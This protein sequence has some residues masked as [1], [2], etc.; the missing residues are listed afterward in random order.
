MERR[1]YPVGIQTFSRLRREG[2]VY[3][4]KTDLVWQLVNENNPF[5]F[6]ARPRRFGK[7]LLASTLHSFFA[8][9]KELFEGLKI[10]HEDW[11][12]KAYPV[13]HL[14][15]SVVKELPSAELLSSRLMLLFKPFTEIYGYDPDENTPGGVLSGLIHRAYKQTGLQVVII[16]DEYDAPLLK[17]LHDEEV[18]EQ[19]RTV[20]QELYSPLKACE[21]YIKRC[22]I[23]GITK[24]SQL[25]IFS[26]IN[27]I[28]TIT[29]LP[30]Y[31]A[32]CG[33]TEEELSTTLAPD[34]ALLAEANNCMPE[35]M[36]QQ[37]KMRYDGYRFSRVSPEI[38]NPFSLFKAFD[39]GEIGNYW[40]DSGTP[41]FLIRQMQKFHTDITSLDRLEAA[42]SAF[43]VPTE[44]MEDAL[45]LLYQ[46]GYLTIKDYERESQ[47]YTL[48]I[49]NQ[50]VRAT[51]QFYLRSVVGE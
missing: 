39:S 18:L 17:S 19:K 26:T 43:D 27:N 30:K 22:F 42:S 50:D 5:L 10:E 25:S 28:S 48:A 47:T 21:Q 33:I 46:S 12:W 29:M 6:F 14:D 16:I 8:G 3:V 23:T 40:F 49:P 32:L 20:L 9:E 7:S 37:L 11:D 15:L 34:V 41:S 51:L 45:P 38:Y 44:A 13:L 31:A 24:F 36:H 2:Y 35:E 1:K 4:D